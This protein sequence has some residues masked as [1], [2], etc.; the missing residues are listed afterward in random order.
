MPMFKLCKKFPPNAIE[1]WEVSTAW[2][3]PVEGIRELYSQTARKVHHIIHN[4]TEQIGTDQRLNIKYNLTPTNPPQKTS[5]DKNICCLAVCVLAATCRQTVKH[6]GDF[7]LRQMW[8]FT[9]AR[10][11]VRAFSLSRTT[12][13]AAVIMSL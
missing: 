6:A 4:R 8:R 9:C 1:S 5:A 13:H 10:R 11:A 2:I 7:M 12:K 3:Q